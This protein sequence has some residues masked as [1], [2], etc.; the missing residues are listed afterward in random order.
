MAQITRGGKWQ[1][2]IIRA[3]VIEQ[4]L[5]YLYFFKALFKICNFIFTSVGFVWTIVLLC[6]LNHIC[7]W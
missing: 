4:F 6:I 7:Y 5:V 3:T 1:I 2:T